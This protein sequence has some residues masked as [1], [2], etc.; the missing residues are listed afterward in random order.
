MGRSHY[1]KDVLLEQ[2]MNSAQNL[3]DRYIY[4]YDLFEGQKELPYCSPTDYENCAA[5]DFFD[6]S[7]DLL[8]SKVK[9]SFLTATQMPN[10]VQYNRLNDDANKSIVRGALTEK[11]FQ[12]I[13]N[14]LIVKG[15]LER[16]NRIDLEY[17]KSRTREELSFPEIIHEGIELHPITFIYP[18]YGMPK[19]MLTKDFIADPINAVS[20]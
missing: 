20:C 16:D 7:D 11:D 2:C 10:I 8:I 3:I 18:K 17:L 6:I 19:L 12:D 14:K 1:I 13:H 9:S 15:C 5:I 4:D